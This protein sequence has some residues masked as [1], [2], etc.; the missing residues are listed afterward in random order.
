MIDTAELGR[1]MS[2]M[3]VPR[4]RPRTPLFSGPMDTV[5][6]RDEHHERPA[7]TSSEHEQWTS[8]ERQL[9]SS[10]R[11]LV[12]ILREQLQAAQERERDYRE[13]IARLTEMLRETQHQNQRLLDMP[14]TAPPPVR[15]QRPPRRGPAAYDPAPAIARILTLR[16]QG[17]SYEAIAA[18]LTQEGIATRYGLPWQHS[19]V[20]YLFCTYG[21]ASM[22]D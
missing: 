1:V 8:S 5:G 3:N 14:R 11:D 21:E 18:Q 4:E 12:D 22:E 16:Q 2:T 7:Q 20:R 9:T 13:H 6:Q 17:L 15:T 10:Y 19:S